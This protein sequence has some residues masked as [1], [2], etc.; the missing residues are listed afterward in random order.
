[1]TSISVKFEEKPK[2]A[3]RSMKVMQPYVVRHLTSGQT[4]IAFI[5]PDDRVYY[6]GNEGLEW[7]YQSVL[8]TDYEVVD[9]KA[10]ATIKVNHD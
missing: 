1:M 4:A 7:D 3:I 6:I 8:Y 10:E 9:I 5:S 2:L